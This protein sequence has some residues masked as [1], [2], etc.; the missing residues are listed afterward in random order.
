VH[1]DTG[2]LGGT[3][4]TSIKAGPHSQPTWCH[5]VALTCA[6]RRGAVHRW[7]SDTS[8]FVLPPFL[9]R[10]GSSLADA[11]L[12]ASSVLQSLKNG[13][14]RSTVWAE[15]WLR[16]K[17]LSPLCFTISCLRIPNCVFT[18]Y[19]VSLFSL[20]PVFQTLLFLTGSQC[21][22]TSSQERASRQGHHT[23]CLRIKIR[24][25]RR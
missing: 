2:T 24:L 3:E 15:S 11:D 13:S 4:D 20:C 23:Y 10:E 19:I 8:R 21:L 17:F 25:Q 18:N 16:K 7:V 22:P 12:S 1:S 5:Y 9:Y 14:D 6:R